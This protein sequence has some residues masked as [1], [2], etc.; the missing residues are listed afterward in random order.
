MATPSAPSSC[1]ERLREAGRQ[2][3]VMHPMR[4]LALLLVALALPVTFVAAC[5]DTTP[6]PSGEETA[7]DPSP[8][9]SPSSSPS[10]SAPTDAVRAVEDLAGV[11]G[12]TPDEVEVVSTEEVTW[13]DGSRGCAKPGEMYTQALVDGLRITLRVAGQTYEYHSGGSQPPSL[14]DEPTE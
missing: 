7:V 13:R 11:L 4:R 8:S 9:P 10:S 1:A 12:V 5:G 14:C 6:P 3:G 2:T